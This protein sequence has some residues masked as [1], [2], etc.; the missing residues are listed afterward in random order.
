MAEQVVQTADTGQRTA[1]RPRLP[2]RPPP[3]LVSRIET[4][5]AWG[6]TQAQAAEELGQ[7]QQDGL[8]GWAPS[9]RTIRDWIAKGWVVVR[10][11]SDPWSLLTAHP[12]EAAL[13]IDLLPVVA[14]GGMRPLTSEEG[15]MAARIRRAAPD[16]PAVICATLA[17]AYAGRRVHQAPT[18]DLDLYVAVRAW[19]HVPATTD[20]QRLGL[21]EY[22]EA[23]QSAGLPVVTVSDVVGR[24][25]WA[26][27]GR[28]TAA[29]SAHNATVS[30]VD[31]V[32]KGKGR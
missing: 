19:R 20:E 5:L 13:M 4:L 18:R 30:T 28:A 8:I 14:R 10:S 2:K 16:V 17:T 7:D 3:E 31:G 11:P 9:E 23:A 12:D 29:A 1:R 6:Y 22:Q 24:A 25:W 27:P 32:G 21:S 15:Q 26:M